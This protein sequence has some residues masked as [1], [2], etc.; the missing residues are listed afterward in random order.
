MD[1]MRLMH[2]IIVIPQ[3]ECVSKPISCPYSIQYNNPFQAH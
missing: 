2:D 3:T 1:L